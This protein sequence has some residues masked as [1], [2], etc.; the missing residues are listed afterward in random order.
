MRTSNYKPSTRVSGSRNAI[1]RAGINK[2][3]LRRRTYE[4]L[5]DAA[6]QVSCQL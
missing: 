6:A 3:A 4:C 2:P 1:Q 5:H